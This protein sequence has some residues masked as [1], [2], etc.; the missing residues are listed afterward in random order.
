MITFNVKLAEV[1]ARDPRF[2][3][4]AYEFVYQA[5]DYTIKMFGS[6][7]P[8]GEEGTE[9]GRH[10]GGRQ[11][12]EGI[13]GLALREFGLMARTVFR[14]WGLR[15]TEDFGS[16]IFNLVAADLMSKTD[17]DSPDDFKA[18]FDFDVDLIEGYEIPLD[19]AR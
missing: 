16:I 7:T 5:L 6:S 14:L 11:L 1:V 8:E 4:E 12:L 18:G 19:E 3:Y 15:K 13:K 10:V 9:I 17:E 2:A